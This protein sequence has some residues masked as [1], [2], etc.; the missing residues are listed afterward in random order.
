MRVLIDTNIITYFLRERDPVLSRFTEALETDTVFVSSDVV[1]YEIR[2]YLVL[3]DAKRQLERYEALSRDWLPV[4][5]TRDDWRT[6]AKLWAELHR[7]GRSIEDR[8]LLIAISALKEQALLVTN[9]T[10]HFEG[11]GVPLADWAADSG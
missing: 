4:S 3:K 8:D 6:A 10:R 1:D 11:L 9:N 7:V 2:R 5:L